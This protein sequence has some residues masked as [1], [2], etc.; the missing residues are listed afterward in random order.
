MPG[1]GTNSDSS[2]TKHSLVAFIVLLIGMVS[3]LGLKTLLAEAEGDA[4][5]KKPRFELTGQTIK[6]NRSGLMWSLNG[7]LTDLTY[8]QRDAFEYIGELNRDRYAGRR[9]WRLPT[10]EELLSL[11]RLAQELGFRGQSADRTVAAGLKS[12]GITNAQP[13]E[14]WSSTAN[15][16]N[17]SEAWFVNFRDGSPGTGDKALYLSVWPVRNAR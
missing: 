13:S 4:K 12:I 17:S 10:R 3:F 15:L 6:D 8:S 5:P 1:I 14:Y 2:S 9:D 7:N 11:A 16:Y